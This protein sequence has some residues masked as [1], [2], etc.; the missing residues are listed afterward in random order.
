[1][2]SS[3][4]GQWQGNEHIAP[5]CRPLMALRVPRARSSSAGSALPVQ[6]GFNARLATLWVGRIKASM[7]SFGDRDAR[8]VPAL[9]AR[10]TKGGRSTPRASTR[11]PWWAWLGGAVETGYVASQP[12]A[13]APRL[14]ALNLFAAVIFGQLLCSVGGSTTTGCSTGEHSLSAGRLC[15][16]LDARRRRGPRPVL[17]TNS[18]CHCDCH[19]GSALLA[20]RRRG[21]SS[22]RGQAVESLDGQFEVLVLRV[23]ELRVRETAQALDEDHHRRHAGAC[24][25]GG[26]VQQSA[27]QPV[28]LRRLPP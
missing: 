1:M 10:K 17:L 5:K 20:R 13:A 9:A 23:L 26:V 21:R 12:W 3:S 7:I 14:G 22:C 2:C 16:D 24:D 28:R 25:L 18:D 11:V 27:R 8:A 6:A 15:G 4:P 19:R